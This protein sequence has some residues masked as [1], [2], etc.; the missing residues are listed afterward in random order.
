MYR[1]YHAKYSDYS[2]TKKDYESE[3]LYRIKNRVGLPM[4]YYKK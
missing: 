3:H 1:F 4:R 2:P